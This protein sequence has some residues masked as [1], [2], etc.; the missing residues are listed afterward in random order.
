M[1]SGD[2]GQIGGL[3]VSRETLYLLDRFEALVRKWNPAINLVSAASLGDIRKRHT[4]DSAQLFRLCPQQATH[5]VDIGTGGGFPGLVIAIIARDLH[6]DLRVT[7]VESDARKATFLRQ[8]AHELG[9]VISVLTDRVEKLASLDVDVLSARALAPLTQLLGHAERHLRRDGA[10]IFP[11]GG[12][13]AE[14]LAEARVEWQFDAEQQPSLTDSNA[15][16]LVIR[17]MKRAKQSD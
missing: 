11:K 17:N 16:I 6:P 2:V 12:R 13:Y 7:L 3:D 1:I 14:E 9:L 4:S 10:A 5:W 15:A 8:A